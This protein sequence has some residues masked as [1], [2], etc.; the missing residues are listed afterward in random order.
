MH[1]LVYV[2]AFYCIIQLLGCNRINISYLI[3]HEFTTTHTSPSSTQLIELSFLTIVEDVN[4]RR[5][6]RC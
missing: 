1:G 6:K 5:Y 2:F 4:S 3:I